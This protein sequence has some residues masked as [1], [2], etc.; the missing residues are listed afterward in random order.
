MKR[1]SGFILILCFII[2]GMSLDA[3]AQ[4]SKINGKIK[5]GTTGQYVKAELITL[6]G[7]DMGMSNVKEQA[8]VGP[9]FT[10]ENLNPSQSR[11]YLLQVTY[12]GVKYNTDVQINSGNETVEVEALVYDHTANRENIKIQNVTYQFVMSGTDLHILKAFDLINESENPTTYF[13]ENGTFNFRKPETAG[14][15]GVSVSTGLVPIR[16]DYIETDREDVLAVNYPLKPGLTQVS[17]AYMVDYTNKDYNFSE[18]L[19]YDYDDF[20]AVTS[21]KDINISGFDLVLTQAD[22]HQNYSIYNT[23]GLKIDD[24][25]EFNL[26]GGTPADPV[27]APPE[28]LYRQPLLSDGEIILSLFVVFVIL[29]MGLLLS[30]N[31]TSVKDVKKRSVPNKMKQRRKNLLADAALLDD[32]FASGKMTEADYQRNRAVV[33]NKLIEI[34]NKID[35][36]S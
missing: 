5:N 30:K 22:A 20:M 28:Q 1:L 4:N 10:I 23:T 8:D 19:L 2:V 26:S 18:E 27:S 36:K 33:K 3:D 29:F 11:P 17:I 15:I 16:Q 34:Y 9:D 25:V 13:N 14:E 31:R 7:F 6:M 32:N 12:K 35:G 21:P 24:L